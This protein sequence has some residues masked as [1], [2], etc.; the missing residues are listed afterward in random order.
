M[1]CDV[2]NIRTVELS[3]DGP[4]WN[5]FQ[6]NNRDFVVLFILQYGFVSGCEEQS[7]NSVQPTRGREKHEIYF[8]CPQTVK[9]LKK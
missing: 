1:G 3:T 5:I 6:R 2:L 8:K 7:E 9:G 4:F